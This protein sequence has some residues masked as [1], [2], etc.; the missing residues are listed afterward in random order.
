M[1]NFY[2]KSC[3][4]IL[5][6]LLV[7]AFFGCQEKPK[8][9]PK[10]AMPTA[11]EISVKKSEPITVVYLEKKGPYSET[12]KAIGELYALIGK[13]GLK[14]RNYPMGVY[15]DDPEKVKPE[16]TKYEVMSQFVGEFKGDAELKMKEIAA[17][18]L[19]SIVYVG[20]Y[21]KCKP[22]YVKIYSWIA[23]NKYEIT[24]PPIEKYLNDP[25]QVAPEQLKTE[26][27]VPVKEAEKIE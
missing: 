22:A 21:E 14:P 17:R 23:K 25:S 20:P 16:E 2:R 7:F 5:V 3:L 27:S 24:G 9:E 10:P 1:L 19:A 8:E 12:G 18:N 15:L 13:K 11:L 26:I 6:T 4:V